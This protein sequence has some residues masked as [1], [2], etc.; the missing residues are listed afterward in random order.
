LEGPVAIAGSTSK[1]RKTSKAEGK[2]GKREADKKLSKKQK[3]VRLGVV[4]VAKVHLA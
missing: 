3:I 1:K 4:R 2:R